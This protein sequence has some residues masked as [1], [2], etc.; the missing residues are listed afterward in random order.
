MTLKIVRRPAGADCASILAEL[1]EWFGIPASNAEY[2][3]F[4]QREP[5]W[6]AEDEDVL[7]VMTLCMDRLLVQLGSA[8]DSG[9]RCYVSGLLVGT[10]AVALMGVRTHLWPH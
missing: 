6:V 8:M 2:A 7:G 4:A 10:R 9:S 5:T 1:P 3:E